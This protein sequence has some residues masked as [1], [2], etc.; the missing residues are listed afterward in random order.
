MVVEVVLVVT[1]IYRQSPPSY[2]IPIAVF[3]TKATLDKKSITEGGGDSGSDVEGIVEAKKAKDQ[4]MDKQRHDEKKHK[5]FL[6]ARRHRQS[7]ESRSWPLSR[8]RQPGRHPSRENPGAVAPYELWALFT[9]KRVAEIFLL[10]LIPALTLTLLLPFCFH[11][12][13]SAVLLFCFHPFTTSLSFSPPSVTGPAT[14]NLQNNMAASSTPNST[15][16]ASCASNVQINRYGGIRRAK[17]HQ[18]EIQ[19]EVIPCLKTPTD[20]IKAILH[21]DMVEKE[22]IKKKK[23]KRRTMFV[24]SVDAFDY[25]NTGEKLAEL[26]DTFIEEIGEINVA[27]LITDNGNLMLEDIGKIPKALKVIQNGIKIAGYIYNHTFV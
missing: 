6:G 18:L 24:K 8:A 4:G 3:S 11:H 10:S 9:L 7:C 1:V 12:F 26:L 13:A 25:A 19:A 27:Q 21:A 20:D 14:H 5:R 22:R 17:R 15:S 23:Y 16:V 2:R